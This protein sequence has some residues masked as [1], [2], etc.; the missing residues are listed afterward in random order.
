M[1]VLDSLGSNGRCDQVDN[2][3]AVTQVMVKGD[4]HAIF[5]AD[6]IKDC[7]DGVGQFDLAGNKTLKFSCCS[8][9]LSQ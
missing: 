8:G 5:E 2:L 3:I 1:D 4:G 6:F 9:P 7:F